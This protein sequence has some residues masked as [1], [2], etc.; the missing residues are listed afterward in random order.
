MQAFQPIKK[1]LGDLLVETNLISRE[2][3]AQALELHNKKGIK[4]GR[5]LLELHF[6]TEDL[7]LAF[8]GRQC[9]ISYV[10]LKECGEIPEKVIRAIPE[11]IARQWEIFPIMLKENEL[12]IAVYDPFNVF[13]LDDLRLLTGYEV[14]TVIAPVDEI[15]AYIDKY[16]IQRGVPTAN[17]PENFLHKIASYGIDIGA[18]EIYFSANTLRYFFN[19]IYLKTVELSDKETEILNEKI[20]AISENP[21][22]KFF[23]YRAP[24]CK[25]ESMNKYSLAP[26]NFDKTSLIK[27]KDTTTIHKLQESGFQPD[28]IL[29]LNKHLNS[30][31]GIIIISGEPGSAKTT[32]MISISSLVAS[33]QEIIYFIGD[34]ASCDIIQNKFIILS[35]KSMVALNEKF[36]FSA[37]YV[38]I[39]ALGRNEIGM[40]DLWAQNSCVVVSTSDETMKIKSPRLYIRQKLVRRLCPRCKENYVISRD[41]LVNSGILLDVQSDEIILSKASGCEF[42]NFTGYCGKTLV[43]F[44]TEEYDKLKH[45]QIKTNMLKVMWNKVLVGEITLEEVLLYR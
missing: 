27:I 3:L 44:M 15:N 41:Y 29:I 34:E 40:L 23:S 33:N 37:H 20:A 24:F 21:G 32:T 36:D 18:T 31:D 16:Y 26:R 5:A 43:Y 6:V 22:E 13:A 1:R 39:D 12:T 45:D 8:L 9:G 38:F 14:K 11:H 35:G 19:L 2:Q 28:D 42:C 17:F 10:S 7:L 25:T 4:L 30:S